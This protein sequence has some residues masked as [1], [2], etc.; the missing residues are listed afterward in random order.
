MV[1]IWLEDVSVTGEVSPAPSAEDAPSEVMVALAVG[2][3]APEG[4]LAVAATV[5]CDCVAE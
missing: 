3:E 5:A 4:G 1:D 2:L